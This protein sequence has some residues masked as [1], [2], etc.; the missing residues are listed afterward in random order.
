MFDKD[1]LDQL[2]SI[3]QNNGSLKKA[4]ISQKTFEKHEITL[5]IEKLKQD[6]KKANQRKDTIVPQEVATED[7][8]SVCLI[9]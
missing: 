4:L 3:K 1:D 8:S 6:S 2:L 9:S 5:K 7:N